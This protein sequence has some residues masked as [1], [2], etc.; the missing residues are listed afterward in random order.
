MHDDIDVGD[1]AAADANRHTCAGLKPCR[2]AARL[3]PCTRVGTDVG[4]PEVGEVLAND[5]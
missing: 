3:E 5:E 2:E 1:A 4:E